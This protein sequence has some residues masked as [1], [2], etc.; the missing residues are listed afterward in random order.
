MLIFKKKV[1]DSNWSLEKN[2]TLKQQWFEDKMDYFKYYGRDMETLFSKCKIAHS[3][4]VFCK[5]EKFKTVLN[6]VD[7]DKGFTIYLDNDEVKQRKQ[8]I[9][10]SIYSMYC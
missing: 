3:R 1:L 7:L 6:T 4:R 8:S 9:N 2:S 5:P 10:P